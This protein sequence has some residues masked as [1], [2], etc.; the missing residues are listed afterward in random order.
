MEMMRSFESI[1]DSIDSSNRKNIEGQIDLFSVQNIKKP[2]CLIPTSKEYSFKELLAMEKEVTGLYLSGHPLDDYLDISIN[3]KTTLISDILNSVDDIGGLKDGEIVKILCIIQ[4]KKLLTTRKKAEMAFLNVEDKS[5]SIEVVVFPTIFNTYASLLKTD[6]VLLLSGKIS[7]KEDEP[8]KILLDSIVDYNTLEKI[9]LQKN[10]QL[11]IKLKTYS[12]IEFDKVVK[13][14]NMYSG[15]TLVTLYFED[16]KKALQLK[17]HGI[18]FNNNLQSQLAE[19]I[20]Q[21]N[22]VFK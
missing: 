21:K 6:S 7:I 5:G 18:N 8:P 22:I 2:E 14:L 17:N 20:G 12:E 3:F 16:T 4:S 13:L 1:I 11:Y 9:N 19:L 15:E 10:K